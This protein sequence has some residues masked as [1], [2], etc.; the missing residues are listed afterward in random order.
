MKYFPE[1]NNVL[2]FG[3]MRLPMKDGE[4]DTAEFS[5]MVD[6]FIENGFNYFDTA[7]GYIGGKS[8]KAIK[9]CLT[10]RY[11]REKFLLADKLTAPYFE[12]EEDIRPFFRSQLD[13]C[14][15]DHFDFYLMHMQNNENFQKFIDCRA[16]E[17][18]FQLKK[19][20]KIRHVGFSFHDNPEMLDKILTKY[21]EVEFVQIQFNYLDIDNPSV[22]SSGC[23]DVVRRHG[24]PVIVMEPVKGGRLAVIPKEADDVLR[25][26][27]TGSNAA[28]AIRYA[29]G[30]DGVAAVL[31]G[32][33]N[34]RQLQDNISFMKDFKPL[35]EKEL[36]A[37]DK[38]REIL[39]RRDVIPCTGCRYCV[40]VC[41]KGIK[42]PDIFTALNKALDGDSASAEKLYGEVLRDS[43]AASECIKCGKCEKSCPQWIGVRDGLKRAA[44]VLGK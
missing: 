3:C 34:L 5:K 9:T 12:K 30:Y 17:T 13:I 7:H 6:T 26:E 35:S 19:E 40:P 11:P 37:V 15:V 32:M 2:G 31:S 16:Y 43:A 23:Y 36:A 25:R 22:Q 38:V 18:A 39:R 1:I 4:V 24:K 33:S 28:V 44:E 42:I 8:E 20:G 27:C 41:P 10:S 29:A 14:G 21:P